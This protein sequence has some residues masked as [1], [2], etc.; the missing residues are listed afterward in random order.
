[1]EKTSLDNFIKSLTYNELLI[2]NITSESVCLIRDRYKEK[3]HFQ[4]LSSNITDYLDKIIFNPNINELT[5]FNMIILNDIYPTDDIINYLYYFNIENLYNKYNCQKLDI[6]TNIQTGFE[7]QRSFSDYTIED[8]KRLRMSSNLGDDK[9]KMK[10]IMTNITQGKMHLIVEPILLNVGCSSFVIRKIDAIFHSSSINDLDLIDIIQKIY[11]TNP[12]IIK[13]IF[14]DKRVTCD[15]NRKYL[16]GTYNINGIIVEHLGATMSSLLV[17]GH[18][19]LYCKVLELF[20]DLELNVYD[21]LCIWFNYLISNHIKT[22]ELKTYMGTLQLITLKKRED[23]I[24]FT[25]IWIENFIKEL[26][27]KLIF[28][29]TKS[30]FKNTSENFIYHFIYYIKDDTM[31]H[32]FINHNAWESSET[33][34]TSDYNGMF[35]MIDGELFIDEQNTREIYDMYFNSND[36]K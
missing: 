15:P 25:S 9:N 29:K 23:D 33:T 7:D 16:L 11:Y 14:N 8:K 27:D 32:F 6:D 34:W 35:L 30:W 24:T 31:K 21:D 5:F 17:E 19:L 22:E 26:N 20:P 2:H 18:M 4:I 12:Q 13:M 1:M 36:C 3:K 10:D 28:L